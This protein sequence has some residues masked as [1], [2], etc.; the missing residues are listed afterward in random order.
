MRNPPTASKPPLAVDG[1]RKD[2]NERR[3]Q[4]DGLL[5]RAEHP[6]I[7]AEHQIPQGA[8]EL[9]EREHSVEVVEDVVMRSQ[10]DHG[11][12][13]DHGPGYRDELEK[14]FH[15]ATALKRR[16]RQVVD[17]NETQE[18]RQRLDDVRPVC[19]DPTRIRD[20][21]AENTNQDEGKRTIESRADE[22]NPRVDEKRSP[23]YQ[24][25]EGDDHSIEL[26]VEREACPEA[27]SGQSAQRERRPGSVRSSGPSRRLS[28]ERCDD[29][30]TAS[31][32]ARTLTSRALRTPRESAARAPA[33]A[34]T[35]SWCVRYPEARAHQSAR[36]TSPC[37][38]RRHVLRAL[39]P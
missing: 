33:P 25:A 8:L 23:P 34:I 38:S 32:R 1:E 4:R 19:A 15:T 20:L 37:A 31:N 36:I 18:E 13:S 6:K 26:E 9:H 22:P 10:L 2:E 3:A 27:D 16:R 21:G 30:A 17:E 5:R 12:N 14:H 7:A 24:H 29:A 28:G 39:P 35:A 11:E